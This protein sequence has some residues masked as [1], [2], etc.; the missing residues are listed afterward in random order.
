M[1][2]KN[3]VYPG[4]TIEQINNLGFGVC[5]IES[6]VVF[7]AGVVTGDVCDIRIIKVHKTWCVG[8][9]ECIRTLSPLRRKKALTCAV[10]PRCGGCVYDAITYSQELLL[11]QEDVVHA[12]KKAGAA[13]YAVA[14]VDTDNRI[15][16]YRNKA[17]YPVG[18]DSEGNICFGFYAPRSHRVIDA[19]ACKLQP[20]IFGQIARR[21]CDIAA[22]NGVKPYDETTHSGVLRH[23]CLRC[24]AGA[25]QIMLVLVIN[26]KELPCAEQFSAIAEE[27]PQIVCFGFSTNEKPDNTV[28]GKS[29]VL[30]RGKDYILDTLC[31]R[32]LAVS[33]LSF[34][35]VNH[36]MAQRLYQ[37]AGE[38][39]NLQPGEKFLDLYCGIGSI[40]LC[41]ARQDTVLIGVEIIPQA[42]K[43]AKENAARNRMENAAFY[44]ADAA[45]IASLQNGKLLQTPFDAV[46]VDPP[47]KGLDEAAIRAVCQM[48]PK[49]IVYISCAPDT[50]ARDLV[51]FVA[52]GYRGDTVYPFDLFPRTGHVESVVLLTKSH[53]K[54]IL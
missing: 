4:V 50:L 10:S 12:L 41:V 7:T 32:T 39:L 54:L 36:D 26:A 2:I 21:V 5:R 17:Q 16:G 40:G 31:G 29:F 46:I 48:S 27:F 11:K 45:Q 25:D 47:R 52:Q 44:C 38:L 3:K 35:Q 34:Y 53:K 13:G 15:T 37:K 14:D 18:T 51:R 20:K 8:K 22:K 30:L 9:A 23:I 1:L 49:R 28:M 42:V 6:I 24:N 19:A 43:N 33:P